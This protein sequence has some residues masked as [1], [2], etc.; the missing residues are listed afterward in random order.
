MDIR[1]KSGIKFR[2]N[3]RRKGERGART[4]RMGKKKKYR[5]RDKNINKI[6]KCQKFCVSL[7]S[8]LD[9]KK[10]KAKW[11][12][13]V[14]ELRG[15][16]DRNHYARRIPG[17]WQYAAVCEKPELSEKTKK[18]KASLPHVKKFKEMMAECKAILHDLERRAEWQARYDEAK[19]EAIRQNKPVQGRLCD[20]VKHEL[21]EAR[22]KVASESSEG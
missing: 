13:L 12:G 7:S 3:E 20:Y 17:N 22:K 4:E 1:E 10:M 14:D 2:A 9:K 21:I 11:T 16:V 8:D 18:K 5:K 6:C 15:H 19:R